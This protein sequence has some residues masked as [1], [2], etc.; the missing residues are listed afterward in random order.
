M[1]RVQEDCSGC[2]LVRGAAGQ[3]PVSLGSERK[4]Q[5]PL[6]QAALGRDQDGI[7]L[8]LWLP[9]RRAIAPARSPC[10]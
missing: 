2:S 10:C 3:S 1:K 7:T 4:Q 9:L 5:V 8:P 6:Q